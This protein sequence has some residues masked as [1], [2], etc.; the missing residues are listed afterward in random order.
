MLIPLY[1]AVF[2]IFNLLYESIAMTLGEIEINGRQGNGIINIERPINEDTNCCSEFS[3]KF[4]H[5]VSKY[6]L[7]LI[8]G[9]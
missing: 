6:V 9:L 4:S 2:F 5:T 3:R 8:F 1:V 7:V